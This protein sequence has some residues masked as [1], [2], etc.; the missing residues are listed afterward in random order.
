MSVL[1]QAL[2]EVLL[3]SFLVYCVALGGHTYVESLNKRPQGWRPRLPHYLV[4]LFAGF[5]VRAWLRST[6]AMG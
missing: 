2:F 5:L 1:L 3:V 6:E 4:L